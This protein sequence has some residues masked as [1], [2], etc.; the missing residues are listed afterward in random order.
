MNPSTNLSDRSGSLV[1]SYKGYDPRV[2]LFYFIIAALLLLLAGGL[3]YQ[4]LFKAEAHNNRERRQNQRRVLV[5]GPRGEILDR[6]GRVLVGN[7][8][9]FAVV[10]YLDEL[11]NEIQKE[12]K[13][14]RIAYRATNDKG[15]PNDTQML[16]IARVTVT[17]R[18]LDRVARVLQREIKV[19]SE[20]LKTHFKDQLLLP[21]PLLEDLEPEE[22][23]RLI[24]R[25]PVRSPLQ[26]YTSST[27]FYPFGSAA[28]HTLG[29]VGLN[30]DI[31]AHDFP[32]K[33]LRTFKIKGSVGRDGLEKKFDPILEGEAGGQIFLVDP[34]GY[35]VDSAELPQKPPVQGKSLTTS[36]DIDLQ[37]VAE[38]ALGDQTGAAVAIDVKTGE[39]LTLA[40]KPDY[41]LTNF[42]P[43]LSSATVADIEQ[44]K[45]WTNL[46][47]G[48]AF[49][50]GS[51][52]KILTTIAALR[53]GVATIDTP[54]TE[55]RGTVQIAN[56]TFYCS[57][58]N[59]HH[60]FVL[61]KDAIAHSCD[62]Y[63]Y[64]AGE[65]TTPD[66]IAEEARRFHLHE[67]TGI[68]LPNETGRM[69]IPDPAYK[70]RTKNEKWFP[71]DTAN[72]SIGQGDVLVTPLEMACF[73]ASVARDEV[74]TKPTLLHRADAP[75]QRSEPIGLTAAQRATLIAGMEGCT[76]YG[77]ASTLTTVKALRV[78]GVRI[79]GKTGTAQKDVWKDGKTGTINY[80]WFICFAPA[81][82]PEIA[83][84]V[85]V[86][87]DTI[88]EAYAGGT[89]AAPIA[90]AILK[91][92]FEKKNRPAATVL[93]TAAQ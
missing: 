28:A 13:L 69:V 6:E 41:N 83:I 77:S 37:L 4:Q 15:L 55:C 8:S 70:L 92:Y 62:I 21:Y 78:P 30:E 3:S 5:P 56:K 72:M 40:S 23:A 29:Y 46:A 20:A 51:T 38:E 86:E 54:I 10:L 48:G 2:I 88:G 67:R 44:R 9:R 64:A 16:Q 63:Y 19:D 61:L 59:G 60:G 1:E 79:A 25:L 87:G 66:G 36:L 65:R 75:T 53:R 11:R 47:I 26:V 17:Q 42:A 81:E 85:T 27:R 73:A 45:A 71:G 84:A 31:Q 34:S 14:I 32:G 89:Y 43:R 57:N 35:R 7:R 58:G 80:A 18:Y 82:N 24:E 33:D 90:S 52:F 76:T 68:E 50:P 39:V 12:Y 74:F 49:P 22:Y 91:K 93:K